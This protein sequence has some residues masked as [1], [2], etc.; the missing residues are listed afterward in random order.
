M[1][2]AGGPMAHEYKTSER[3]DQGTGQRNTAEAGICSTPRTPAR[4][5][6]ACSV[7]LVPLQRLVPELGA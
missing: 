3:A 5:R 7:G 6:S 4:G 1:T 2:A